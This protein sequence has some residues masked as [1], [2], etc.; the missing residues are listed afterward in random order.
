MHSLPSIPYQATINPHALSQLRIEAIMATMG[1]Y[2]L[3]VCLLQ[4]GGIPVPGDKP[5]EKVMWCLWMFCVVCQ[6]LAT[7]LSEVCLVCAYIG[8]EIQVCE[9]VGRTCLDFRV[10]QAVSTLAI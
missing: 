3:L 8:L 9:K 2:N 4:L 1:Q 6:W 5:H 7:L 10:D